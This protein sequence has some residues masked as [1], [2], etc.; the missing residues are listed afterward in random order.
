MDAVGRLWAFEVGERSEVGALESPKRDYAE[1]PLSMDAR[2]R[3]R[4]ITEKSPEGKRN[5]AA[6]SVPSNPENRTIAANKRNKINL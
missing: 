4:G 6:R 3:L 1:I 5:A 2:G